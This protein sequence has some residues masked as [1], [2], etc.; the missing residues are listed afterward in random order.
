[1][2]GR[3]TS[4]VGLLFLIFILFAASAMVEGR[5]CEAP[6]GK[7]HGLCIGSGGCSSVCKNVENLLSGYCKSG[8]CICRRNC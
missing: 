2:M 7:Y 6:S 5:I 3:K 8:A 4:T 1:M